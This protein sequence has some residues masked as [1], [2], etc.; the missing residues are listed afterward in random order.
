MQ[1]FICLSLARVMRQEWK[2]S[3][4]LWIPNIA[5]RTKYILSVRNN[6]I[7]SSA[8]VERKGIEQLA[9]KTYG[10]TVESRCSSTSSNLLTTASVPSAN[11]EELGEP[12]Q[13][14]CLTPRFNFDVDDDNGVHFKLLPFRLGMQAPG[15]CYALPQGT[16]T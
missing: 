6:V 16:K 8:P 1:H 9:T 7:L 5:K 15:L 4:S 10:F 12:L 14:S 13:S 3:S 11:F 2:L